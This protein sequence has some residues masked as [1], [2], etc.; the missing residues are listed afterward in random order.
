MI[1]EDVLI[2]ILAAWAGLIWPFIVLDWVSE[3][4]ARRE[5]ERLLRMR[6][7]T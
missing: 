4:L 5:F 7:P 1:C 3:W 6:W 2:V